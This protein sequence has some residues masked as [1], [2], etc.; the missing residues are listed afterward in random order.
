MMRIV[1]LFYCMLFIPLLIPAGAPAGTSG[2][3]VSPYGLRFAEISVQGR[4][5]GAMIDFGDAYAR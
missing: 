3:R 5:V 4:T 1:R 2:F